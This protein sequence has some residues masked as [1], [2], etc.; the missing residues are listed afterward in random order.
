MADRL[1][2]PLPGV[3]VSGL[4]DLDWGVGLFAPNLEGR[5]VPPRDVLA[6]S[7]PLPILVGND[8]NLSALGEYYFGAAQRV[9]A[10]I[11]KRPITPRGSYQRPMEERKHRWQVTKPS[12]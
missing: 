7:L 1:G 3:G 8:T 12:P 11:H 9:R 10:F 2:L 6:E 5:D 4:I